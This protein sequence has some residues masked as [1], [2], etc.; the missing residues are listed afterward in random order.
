[1]RYTCEVPAHASRGAVDSGAL[2]A[3]IDAVPMA[4]SPGV[5]PLEIAMVICTGPQLHEVS[6]ITLPVDHEREQL[7]AWFAG[8]VPQE[9]QRF[10][11][12]GLMQEA[13]SNGLMMPMVIEALA[14][15]LDRVAE[16]G[17]IVLAA[18][19]PAE[20]RSMVRPLIKGF[21]P[22]V[23]DL[24]LVSLRQW[25]ALSEVECPDLADWGTVSKPLRALDHCL[26]LIDE[27]RQYLAL[28]SGGEL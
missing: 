10:K 9:Q 4:G 21:R 27:A 13:L 11:R 23:N 18:E 17:Q 26:G 15:T 3:W 6:A 14:Q 28:F 2:V 8:L 24:S 22:S 20:V 5:D 19:R 7:Q 12:S 16:P 1:M 25:G